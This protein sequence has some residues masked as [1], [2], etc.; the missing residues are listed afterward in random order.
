MPYIRKQYK[1]LIDKGYFPKNAGELNYAMS[2][3]FSKYIEEKGLCYKNINDILG[4]I[5]GSKMEFY[6][7]VVAPYEDLKIRENGDLND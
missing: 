1:E 4:A 5:E 3:I 7:R 6:R 2:K